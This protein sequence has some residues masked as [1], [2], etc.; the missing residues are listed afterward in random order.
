VHPK[1]AALDRKPAPYSAGLPR[2]SDR[3]GQLIFSTWRRQTER[4]ANKIY[5]TRDEALADVFDYI[6][7]SYNTIRRH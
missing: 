6:E 2:C 7:R 5:R 3:N 4:T 1:P